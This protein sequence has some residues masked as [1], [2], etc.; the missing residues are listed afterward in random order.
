MVIHFVKFD[1]MSK[2]NKKTNE[3]YRRFSIDAKKAIVKEIDNGLSKL[4]A[5]RRYSVSPTTIYKW[6]DLYSTK[7]TKPKKVIVQST[8]ESDSYLQQKAKI[9]QLYNLLGRSQTEVMFLEKLIELAS[10]EMG[11]DL[12]KNFASKLSSI[13]SHKKL[14]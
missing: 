6:L 4:E 1:Y 13:S 7:F 5:S 2:K 3:T 9:D 8:D 14:M 12:K 11:I 10:E